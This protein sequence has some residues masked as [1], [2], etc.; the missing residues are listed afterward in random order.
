VTPERMVRVS[1]RKQVSDGNYGTEAAEV[2]LEWAMSETETV[3]DDHRTAAAM[4][5]QARTLV[6]RELAMSPSANVRRLFQT[7]T[8]APSTAM[9]VP[10][11]YEDED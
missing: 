4:L 3:V 1:F 7:R 5:E 6:Q 8:T 11:D 9:R 10:T 2:S